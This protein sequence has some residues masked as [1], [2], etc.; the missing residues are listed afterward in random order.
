MRGKACQGSIRQAAPNVHVEI[1]DT[2]GRQGI[3]PGEILK[4]AE[5]AR[6][7][8]PVQYGTT[9]LIGRGSQTPSIYEGLDVSP[10]RK[11]VIA[12]PDELSPDENLEEPVPMST[13]Y[14]MVTDNHPAAAR[15]NGSRRDTVSASD[16]EHDAI[17]MVTIKSFF[18][19][20]HLR[21]Q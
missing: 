15:G 13:M 19:W 11:S 14:F 20:S 17:G 16:E 4:F 6:I 3:S 10:D 18:F 21:R 9:P 1:T 5:G 7:K 8:G 2:M 12:E